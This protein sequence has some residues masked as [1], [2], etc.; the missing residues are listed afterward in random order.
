MFPDYRNL[1]L[2]NYPNKL[3][4]SKEPLLEAL[5]RLR[6]LARDVITS[7]K[8]DL[9]PDVITLTVATAD[10]GMGTE[11]VDAKYEGA[12]LT[13]RFN[14]AYMIDGLEAVT[15]DEVVVSV[16]DAI[17]QVILTSTD[18]AADDFLYLLMPMR[19]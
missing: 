3:V 18:P 7:V 17:K 10:L 8:V 9:K 1:I 12:E 5:R 2:T 15:G 14:P 4:V 16:F 11:D 19:V 6:L 13:V